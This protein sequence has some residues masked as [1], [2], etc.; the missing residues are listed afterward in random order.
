MRFRTNREMELELELFNRDREIIQ[1]R[2]YREVEVAQLDKANAIEQAKKDAE[3]AGLKA[4]AAQLKARLAES[5]YSQLQDIL[6]ALV[7][8]LPTMDI[9]GITVTPR[10]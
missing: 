2:A 7:V 6:K 5:P 1:A 8:K 10:E 4:E 3:I 9:K